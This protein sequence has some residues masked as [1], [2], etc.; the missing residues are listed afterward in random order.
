MSF[1]LDLIIRNGIVVTASDQVACDIG[2]KDGK[3]RFLA[4]GLPSLDGCQEIDAEGGY[5]TPG[6]VDSHVHVAQSAAKG[7]GARSADDWGSATRSALAGKSSYLQMLR[8]RCSFFSHKAGR[9]RFWPLLSRV[10]ELRLRT[11]SLT[12][13]LSLMTLLSVITASISSSQ[14][15]MST[16]CIPSSQS[17]LKK[18]S[19]Q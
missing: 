4:A 7:L 17:L 13:T 9:P 12:I 8:K 10:G 18:G 11:P 1:D 14:T 15:P 3:I 6:G 5:I 16:K 19:H 2:I